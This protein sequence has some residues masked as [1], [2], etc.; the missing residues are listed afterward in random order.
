MGPALRVPVA[1]G[2]AEN[3]TSSAAVPAAP[4][5][6][7]RARCPIDFSPR[8]GS[9]DGVHGMKRVSRHP[10]FWSLAAVGL[11]SALT[12]P[13]VTHVVM[14]GMPAVFALIGG[15]H[16]DYRYRRG[17]GGTLPPDV[18]AKTSLLPFGALLTG[19]QAWGDLAAEVKWTNACLAVALCL[20][21]PRSPAMGLVPR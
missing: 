20:L 9:P 16:Q 8:G 10:V 13:Y 3:I 18:D 1:F 15:A 21:W 11:G 6:V 4:Q 2:G 19:R 5:P 14:F 7:L 12:T 17:W